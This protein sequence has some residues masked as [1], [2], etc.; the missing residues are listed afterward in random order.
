MAAS[1][2]VAASSLTAGFVY[3]FGDLVGPHGQSWSFGSAIRGQRQA[4][5]FA[6]SLNSNI[7]DTT[8]DHNIPSIHAVLSSSQPSTTSAIW[9]MLPDSSTFGIH[10]VLL[11]TLI[12]MI[13]LLRTATF[14]DVLG[15][16]G[17]GQTGNQPAGQEQQQSSA[18]GDPNPDAEDS[19]TP[20]I[21]DETPGEEDSMVQSPLSQDARYRWRLI[22]G[23]VLGDV[24]SQKREIKLRWK[25]VTRGA[26]AQ[27]RSKKQQAIRDQEALNEA[28]RN[29]WRHVLARVRSMVRSSQVLTQQTIQAQHEAKEKARFRWRL[30]LQRVR[31]SLRMTRSLKQQAALRNQ[32]DRRA[33]A[34][35]RWLKV[36]CALLSRV[37]QEQHERQL[38]FLCRANDRLRARL[39]TATQELAQRDGSI[40]RQAQQLTEA[41]QKLNTTEAA[42]R[43]NRQE[44]SS[45]K[46]NL[47]QSDA[48]AEGLQSQLDDKK[49]EC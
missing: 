34:K 41:T 17:S 29:R 14:E 32:Q 35:F 2:L 36:K 20:P 27:I 48:F 28:T 31:S 1:F 3:F 21:Q 42:L 46:E 45:L 24:R 11:V 7:Y 8:R 4:Q 44:N 26:L 47:A 38:S 6:S 9:Q 10:M 13:T 25:F 12:G 30:V 39:Q 49:R 37:R 22:G 18:P 16:P 40:T 43:E 33:S 15:N 5:E 19:N 23:L